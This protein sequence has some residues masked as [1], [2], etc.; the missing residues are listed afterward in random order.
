LVLPFGNSEQCCYGRGD[1]DISLRPWFQFLL[2]DM[3]IIF[4]IFE[5]LSYCFPWWPYNFTFPQ[6]MQ[7]SSDFFISVLT[8]VIFIFLVFDSGHPSGCEVAIHCGFYLHF[9]NY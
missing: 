4:L 7:K 2:D 5:E 1:V 8:L 3:V 6:T 9:P